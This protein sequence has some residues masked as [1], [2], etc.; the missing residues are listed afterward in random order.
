MAGENGT[1]RGFCGDISRVQFCIYMGERKIFALHMFIRERNRYIKVSRSWGNF[2][3][4]NDIDRSIV[5][6]V[7]SD[8]SLINMMKRTAGEKMRK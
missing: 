5:I 7:N 2:V 4:G 8:R 3:L 1:R 6:A